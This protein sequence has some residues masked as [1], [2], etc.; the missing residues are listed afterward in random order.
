[1]SLLGGLCSCLLPVGE[2]VCAG[3]LNIDSSIDFDSDEPL[4]CTR[5]QEGDETCESCQ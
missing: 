2:C 3:D 5:N 1:M 4:V